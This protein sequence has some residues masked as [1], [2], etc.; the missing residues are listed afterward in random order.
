MASWTFGFQKF[1]TLVLSQQ[2][3]SFLACLLATSQSCP[4]FDRKLYQP[5]CVG[6]TEI[7][8]KS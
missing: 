1:F 8:T 6:A 4:I 2:N 3:P 5:T 7:Q